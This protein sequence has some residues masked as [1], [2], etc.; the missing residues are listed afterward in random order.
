MSQ[1]VGRKSFW[2]QAVLHGSLLGLA[3]SVAEALKNIVPSIKLHYQQPIAVSLISLAF[4]LFLAI[5]LSLLL[6]P[7]LQLRRGVIFHAVSTIT[8]FALLILFVPS[9]YQVMAGVVYLLIGLTAVLYALGLWLAR[10][11]LALRV[12]LVGALALWLIALWVPHVV[13]PVKWDL[14][15]NRALLSD[16]APNVLLIVLDTVRRDRLDLSGYDR[17]TFPWLTQFAR[18]GAVFSRA[19]SAAPWTMPSHASIFTGLFPSA[20][21]AHHEKKF[22]DEKLTTLAEILYANGWTTVAMSSNPWISRSSGMTQGFAIEKPV[23]MNVTEPSASFAYR[24]AWNLGLLARDHSGRHTTNTWLRWLASQHDGRPFFAFL[25]YVE[26]HFPY[27]QLPDEHLKT[28]T[29]NE[30]EEEKIVEASEAMMQAEAN[31][32]RLDGEQGVVVSDLYDSAIHYQ[33]LLVEEAVEALRESGELDETLIVIVS[34]HGELL[35]E[36]D[37]FNH[38]RSLTE[39]LISVPLVMRYPARIPRGMEI[40]TP[41]TTAALMPTILDLV[42][43]EAPTDIHTRSFAPLFEGSASQ[44]ISP[45]LSENFR[46]AGELLNEGFKHRDFFDRLG[47]RYRSIEEDGWKLVV[48]SEGHRWLFKPEE[49]PAEDH[50]LLD[51]FPEIAEKL[52]ATME[53]LVEAYGLVPLDAE[54]GEAGEGGTE[55][56][57]EVQE[58]LRALGYAG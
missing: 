48:D 11:H 10:N 9:P 32:E 15:S 22:L 47:V 51:E 8:L 18:D 13:S 19:I 56:D 6:A 16:D 55:L 54:L 25:N 3:F 57:P 29:T 33:G 41:V 45:L 43:L 24:V 38:S 46:D 49:D 53:T 31:G 42:G 28:F 50:N 20:H 1:K 37:M 35:G 4:N 44:A 2:K 58:R 27:H 26:P 40:E 14:D 5:L 34:D 30:I 21:G 23:W 12:G 36:H 17:A 39:Q 7:A 52:T